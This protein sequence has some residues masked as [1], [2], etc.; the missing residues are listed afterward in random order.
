M[1]IPLCRENLKLDHAGKNFLDNQNF[2][3]NSRNKTIFYMY[4]ASLNS[5]MSVN[6]RCFHC[7][8]KRSSLS[9]FLKLTTQ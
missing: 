2:V 8:K 4:N 1:C 9:R 6:I 5:D 3:A 7:L